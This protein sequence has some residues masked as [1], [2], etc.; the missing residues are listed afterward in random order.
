MESNRQSLEGHEGADGRGHRISVM[1]ST[2][3]HG[4]PKQPS[5][6]GL[7][8]VMK[9]LCTNDCEL[10]FERFLRRVVREEVECKIQDFLSSRGW[11]NQISTSRATP[12]ELRFVTRTPDIIFTNSNVISEDKTSIQIALFDVRD[13]SVVNVGP[14]SSLKVEICALNGE[15]GSNG[16]EDWTEGEFNA[17]ILRERDGRRPLLNGDRFITLKNGVGCVNKL[18]FTDNSRWI[19]SRKFRLGAK[20][21]PPISIEANIK[22]GR[23]EPF[24]VKDYRG[25][26]YKKH[27][28]PSLNDDVWRLE[29]IAKDGKIHDRLSL[30]GIHTVQ[31]LL[32]LYTTNP[33]SLLEKVGNITKRSWITIIEHAKT[34]AID[35]DETFVYHTAEQSIGLL[36]NS[37]YI[38]V[39]VTFD[40]QNYLS[41]DILNPNEK[42]LVETLKQHAYKNTDNFKSIHETSLSCS[43]PLTFLGV[44]QSDATEQSL[45]RFNIS[46]EQEGH[47][48]T[49]VGNGQPYASTSYTDESVHSYQIYADPVPDITDMPLN[50][51]YGSNSMK[52]FFSGLCIEGDS[53]VPYG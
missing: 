26:A 32:R 9:G 16:S 41:P 21:V 52:D 23:S 2:Q 29:Q 25:E 30:H 48:G 8:N 3:K 22:E 27:H 37:I 10:H 49:W 38:L 44:G 47:Q 40:G 12:F 46:T 45:Q 31:D 39:G 18:V 34:C 15:F 42:H 43:K 6:S 20:V 19:R 5:L 51:P 28:P 36:F 1:Q 14:L 11:V 4:D 13:Q 24:V 53:W 7:R 50:N 17:N 35:D 33:S